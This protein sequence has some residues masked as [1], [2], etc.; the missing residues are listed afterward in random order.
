MHNTTFDVF[1]IGAGIA[2]LTTA[3][4]AARCGLSVC[5]AEEALFG[6]L[7][8]N[9]NHLSP[10]L[11]G[12]P[13]SGADLSAAKMSTVTDLGV[14]TLFESVAAVEPAS[15]GEWR[16]TTAGGAHVARSVVA[17][18]GA[19]LRRLGVPGEADF[20][21]RGVSRCADC[22]GPMFRGSSVVVVGG[23]DSALQ[24]ALVLAEFCAAVHVV[25]RREVW[26]GRDDLALALRAAPNVTTH[27]GKVVE[28]ILGDGAVTAVRLRD[29][30]SGATDDLPCTGVFAYVGLEPNVDFLPEG[31]RSP[32]GVHVDD[33]LETSLPGIFAI[34]AVRRGHQGGLTHAVHD[35][36]A[37]VQTIEQ[38]LA[39]R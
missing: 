22:D 23:G 16:V 3:E 12:Q 37:V 18:S 39:R 29:V 15:G 27:M 36:R 35:A 25:H 13:D 21:G 10:G 6:G 30:G 11:E 14:T 38:R 28:T 19:R 8:L 4:L 31:L 26:R 2:G 1:V 5:L 32:Q 17:A 24:E 7:V 20:E 9:V 34:G 33:R